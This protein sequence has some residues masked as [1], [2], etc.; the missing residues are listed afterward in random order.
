[1]ENISQK[2][3]TLIKLLLTSSLLTPLIFQNTATYADEDD[4]QQDTNPIV[5]MS[6]GSDF[7][8]AL[9]KD[10]KLTAWGSN[11]FGQRN[12]PQ[13]VQNNPRSFTAAYNSALAVTGEGKVVGWGYEDATVLEEMP[14]EELSK[15]VSAVASPTGNDKYAIALKNNE[16]IVWG[17]SDAGVDD[18]PDA[19]KGG[20]V[21]KIA[22]SLSNPVALTDSGSVI[23]WGDDWSKVNDVPEEAKANVV[24]IAVGYRHVIALKQ[25]GSIVTWGRED[26]GNL[27]IPEEAKG[28]NIKAVAAGGNHSLALTTEGKVIAWGDSEHDHNELSE[29][30]ESNVSKIYDSPY[31]SLAL[32]ET[33]SLLAW[34]RTPAGTP[35]IEPVC[36]TMEFRLKVN[37]VPY[38]DYRFYDVY[39]NFAVFYTSYDGQHK[40]EEKGLAGPEY[41]IRKESVKICNDIDVLLIASTNN[42]SDRQCNAPILAN[43]YD[44]DH[45]FYAETVTDEGLVDT[46]W[47]VQYEFDGVVVCSPE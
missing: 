28:N 26:E 41:T 45:L 40:K 5:D 18:I 20:T 6:L 1:M 10:G 30:T 12:I 11:E 35:G 4:P 17:R 24:D 29:A 7:T 16:L 37:H 23:A 43:Y 2:S 19:A 9:N 13:D 34:G 47:D 31:Y 42:A 14:K 25:D 36:S 39:A 15:D 46:D 21:K 33:G 38:V 22:A 8:L 44:R 3:F 32:R 27:D